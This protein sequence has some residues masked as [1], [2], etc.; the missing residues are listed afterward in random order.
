MG[1][2]AQGTSL[3]L[4]LSA[5]SALPA[6]L[7]KDPMLLL[8]LVLATPLHVQRRTPPTLHV[9]MKNPLAVSLMV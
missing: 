3:S 1:A 5:V 9:K 6:Q 7:R 8:S 2:I 4:W